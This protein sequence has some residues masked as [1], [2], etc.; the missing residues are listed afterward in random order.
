MNSQLPLQDARKGL[1]IPEEK[2]IIWRF[3]SAFGL[4]WLIELAQPPPL[5]MGVS[6]NAS[7]APSPN[8]GWTI[9][10]NSRDVVNNPEVRKL[11]FNQKVFGTG[12]GCC[13]N[14][15]WS[16]RWSRK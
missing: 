8:P 7:M 15:T 4:A 3:G 13:G 10:W 11:Y 1:P 16:I 14:V 2:N 5:V 9:L 6:V 12:I